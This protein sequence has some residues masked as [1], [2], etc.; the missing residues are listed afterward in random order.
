MSLHDYVAGQAI[1]SHQFPFYGLLQ[2]AMRAADSDNFSILRAAFPEVYKD[3]EVRYN[4][5]GGSLP[6]DGLS[7]EQIV[8]ICNAVHE[9]YG[10]HE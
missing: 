4:A 1:D 7:W 8:E 10:R 3:L 5:P 9:R 2:A 6:E